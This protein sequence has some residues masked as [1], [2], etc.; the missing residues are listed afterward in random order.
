MVGAVVYGAEVERN[1]S[2]RS[3]ELKRGTQDYLHLENS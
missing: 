2:A 1:V 3:Y